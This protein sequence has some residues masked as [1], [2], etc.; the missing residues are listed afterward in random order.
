VS[1]TLEWV[2]TVQIGGPRDAHAL[3]SAAAVGIGLANK[4]LRDER[5]VFRYWEWRDLPGVTDG[6]GRSGQRRIDDA[7]K[8]RNDVLIAI[9]RSSLG[10]S[11]ARQ[12]SATIREIKH[13]LSEGRR[14]L[15]YAKRDIVDQVRE[16]MATHRLSPSVTEFTSVRDLS[17]RI[18]QDLHSLEEPF[19]NSIVERV[20]ALGR[21][22]AKD[23]TVDGYFDLK[24]PGGAD[25]APSRRLMSMLRGAQLQCAFFEPNANPPRNDPDH[26][27]RIGTVA[28]PRQ[29]NLK[30]PTGWL[31][32]HMG[33]LTNSFKFFLEVMNSTSE[34]MKWTSVLTHV[35]AIVT[36]EGSEWDAAPGHWRLWF[37]HP[38]AFVHP[39]MARSYLAN[40][41]ICDLSQVSD[42]SR[43]A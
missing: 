11:L 38:D 17:A 37:L 2:R 8:N 24:P 28:I 22:N 36:G 6:R 42:F 32:D 19:W 7:G 23:A 1:L 16:T 4:A 9:F 21:L 3:Y 41:A 31:R 27:N 18:Y 12:Q 33:D 30:I 34:R 13:M 20:Q 29:Y 25:T 5:R 43:R 39:Y 15:V 35:S 14:V 26:W 10:Q 40:N